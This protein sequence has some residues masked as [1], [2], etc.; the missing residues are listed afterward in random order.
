MGI[1]CLLFVP[2]GGAGGYGRRR[3]AG[4]VRSAPLGLPAR[5]LA[6]SGGGDSG[7]AAG[8]L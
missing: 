2:A 5:L 3:A 6:R 7:A 1:V 8:H 4:R